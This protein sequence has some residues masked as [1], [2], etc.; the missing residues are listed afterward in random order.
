MR[1]KAEKPIIECVMIGSLLGLFAG[2]FEALI[3]RMQA[4]LRTIKGRSTLAARIP[5]SQKPLRLLLRT[6]SAQRVSGLEEKTK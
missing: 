4:S 3:I 2:S 1:P 6:L 5:G